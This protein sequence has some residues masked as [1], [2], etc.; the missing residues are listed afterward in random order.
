VDAYGALGDAYALAHNWAWHFPGLS[1]ESLLVRAERAAQRG[2]ALDSGSAAAWGAEASALMER[3]AL[4]LEG[5]VPVARRAI[6][7]DPRRADPYHVLGITL[8]LRGDDSAGAATLT[9]ALALEPERP[10]TLCWLANAALHERQYAVAKR[11]ADSAL[12]IAPDFTYALGRRAISRTMLGDTAGGLRDAND[13]LRTARGDS[14]LALSTLAWVEGVTGDTAAARRHARIVT[15]APG[16]VLDEAT[17]WAAAAFVALGDTDAAL[18]ALES[19]PHSAFVRFH[20]GLEV[21]DPIR[22]DPRF[23]QLVELLRG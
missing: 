23:R 8:L 4:T 13:A 9:Q 21:F 3:N 6:A 20:L 11:W 10:I 7:L 2:L 14:L 16:S 1:Q 12:A 5:V 22:D 17:A 19:A 15:T 18:A